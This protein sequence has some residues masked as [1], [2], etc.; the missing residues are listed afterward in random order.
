MQNRS[1]IKPWRLLGAAV[2]L[3]GVIV[4][5]AAVLVTAPEAGLADSN[6][7]E[8]EYRGELRDE[9]NKPIAGIYPLEFKLYKSNKSTVPIWRETHWVAVNDGR[10]TLRLGTENRLRS[11]LAKPGQTLQLGVFLQNGGELLRE[12]ITFPKPEKEDKD[13]KE[14]VKEEA[15]P[16]AAKDDEKGEGDTKGKDDKDDKAAPTAG[17]EKP[18]FKTES[19]FAEVADYARRAGVAEDAEKVGGKSITELEA[20]IEKLREQIAELR[21]MVR[22]GGKSEIG[23]DVKILPRVGGTGGAPFER[24]CP[25]NHTAT[26]IRGSSGALVDSIQ[27]VCSP[28]E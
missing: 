9:K 17:E 1:P 12:P 23:T 27:L 22:S 14:E 19:S 10:Y 26:G 18:T 20:E 15:D 25:P 28:I 8:L 11:T 24:Q 7:V 13:A 6:A 3:L 16:V 5:G 21:V 4:A 2:A